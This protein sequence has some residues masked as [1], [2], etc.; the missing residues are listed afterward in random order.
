MLTKLYLTTQALAV[1]PLQNIKNYQGFAII[2]CFDN[3]YKKHKNFLP[4]KFN[5]K[6]V[7]ISSNSF[8]QNHAILSKRIRIFVSSIIDSDYIAI[9][10]ESYL[11]GMTNNC[12]NIIHYTNSKFIYDDCNYNNK[13]YKKNIENYL[14]DYNNTQISN[15][16]NYCLLNLSKL[17][18]NLIKKIN[19]N[20]YLKIVIISCHHDDFWKKRKFLSNYRLITRKRF[21][22]EKIGYFITINIFIPTFIGLGSNCSIA[23][24]MKKI[25]IR[26]ESFPFDWCKIKFRNLLEVF[27]NNFDNFSK[28]EVVKF[29]ENHG[30]SYILKNKYCNF[31]HEVCNIHELN[32]F[33]NILEKRIK[34]LLNKSFVIFVRI[35]LENIN[36]Y[37]EL[38]KELDKYFMNYKLV[39][40]S[41]KKP[42]GNVIHFELPNFIDWKFNNFEWNMIFQH[43]LVK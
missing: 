1:L 36:D 14:V 32:N 38:E 33:E 25:G 27:R 35:E 6:L 12:N 42:L 40:I 41:K 13:F 30:N 26:R 8:Q 31:A 34:R 5:D 17:P 22:C 9:G 15:K 10:G 19:R 29:S 43:F 7:F 39:V 16:Y 18:E 28:L 4:Q 2:D 11:Y 3:I 20:L 23:Y 21:I 24:Q 37:R